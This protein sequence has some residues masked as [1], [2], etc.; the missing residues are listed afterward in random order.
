MKVSVNKHSPVQPSTEQ[1]CDKIRT[2]KLVKNYRAGILV[3]T[4]LQIDTQ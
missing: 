1:L 2:F 3:L 4:Y